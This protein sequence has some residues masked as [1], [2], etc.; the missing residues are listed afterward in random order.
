MGSI[1][2]I[3]TILLISITFT[4]AES[5]IMDIIKDIQAEMKNLKTQYS[6]MEETLKE[7]Q[8]NLTKAQT[9]L[10]FLKEPPYSHACGGYNDRLQ[11]T[12]NTI[13]Y[14]T[15]LYSSTNV[16][17]GGLD[18]ETGVF[19]AG[20]PGSYT[21]TWSLRAANDAGEEVVNIHLRKNGQTIPDSWHSSYC[22]SK[23][24]GDQGGRTLVLHLETG[25][26]LDLFCN[27]CSAGIFYPTFCVSLTTFDII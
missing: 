5:D 3:I 26:T 18:I 23:N 19:T 4:K 8:E 14:K 24:V 10:S 6:L 16:K 25:D 9:A 1:S 22:G 15:L 17:E 2:R 13:S 11:L 20:W 7:T 27:D 21:I 12:S